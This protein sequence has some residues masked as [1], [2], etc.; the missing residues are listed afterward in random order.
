MYQGTCGCFGVVEFQTLGVEV[1]VSPNSAR[2]PRQQ[3]FS[4]WEWIV[5]GSRCP[6]AMPWKEGAVKNL[7]VLSL[8]SNGNTLHWADTSVQ[9]QYLSLDRHQCPRALPCIQLPKLHLTNDFPF[10]KFQPPKLDLTMTSNFQNH[11]KSMTSNSQ[12]EIK[13]MTSV[14]SH[15][16]KV[17]QHN[18]IETLAPLFHTH[19][20]LPISHEVLN[21]TSTSNFQNYM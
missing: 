16:H 6:M 12:N 21:P 3:H 9:C 15:H 19:I 13:Q 7:Q 8:L 11:I 17:D 10:P 1:W 2:I 5:S 20:C 14:R 18:K 4:S